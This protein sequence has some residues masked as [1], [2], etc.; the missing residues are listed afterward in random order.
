MITALILACMLSVPAEAGYV[1]EVPV[2]V[3]VSDYPAL[4]DRSQPV[5]KMVRSRPLRR[6]LDARPVRRMFRPKVR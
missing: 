1:V 5:R 4:S 2:Y 3:V 6:L